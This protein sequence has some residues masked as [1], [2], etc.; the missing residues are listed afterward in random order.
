MSRFWYDPTMKQIQDVRQRLQDYVQGF[1]K[2][3]DAEKRLGSELEQEKKSDAEKRLGSELEQ[4]RHKRQRMQ[5]KLKRL[6]NRAGV[7][8]VAEEGHALPEPD[9]SV[10]KLQIFRALVSLL[11]PGKMLDLGAGRGNFSLAAV[12]L[13]WEVTAVDARTM[14]WP[15]YE[16]DPKHAQLIRSVDWVVADVREFPIYSGEYDLICILG[17]LHHLELDDQI[18]LLRRCSDTLTL[19]DTRVAPEIVVTEGSYEGE[20][21][22]EPGETR[23]ER[24]KVPTAS[25]GNEVSFRHTEESLLRL[26]QDCGYSKTMAMKPPHRLDY[27]FYL[28]LPPP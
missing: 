14:R 1:K 9:D 18:K 5:S 8:A 12:E 22:S 16:E 7:P 6:Q 28:C 21:K 15:D 23:E 10:N 11:K 4:E 26:A 20:Y 17:L 27:T 3:S 25:W 19:L 2:K 24:D 13:G